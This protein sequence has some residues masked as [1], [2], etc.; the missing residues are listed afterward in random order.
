M[1]P[2]NDAPAVGDPLLGRVQSVAQAITDRVR[3]TISYHPPAAD[4][5]RGGDPEPPAPGAG[6]G[7]QRRGRGRRAGRRGRVAGARARACYGGEEALDALRVEVPDVL[8]LDL[9]MPRVSGVEVATRG[10]ARRGQ[11]TPPPVG[12]DDGRWGRWKTG[13]M[14]MPLAGFHFHLVKPVDALGAAVRPRPVPGGSAARQRPSSGAA[15]DT[16]SIP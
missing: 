7:R 12:R 6:G 13:R 9:S 16:V 2:A 1:A 15:S 8:L 11:R 10:S 3:A 5:T 4:S 14:A